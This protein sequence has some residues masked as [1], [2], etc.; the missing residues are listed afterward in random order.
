MGFGVNPFNYKMKKQMIIAHRGESFI[1]PENTLASV[2]LAWENGADAVEVDIRLTLDKKIVVIHDANTKRVSGIRK[3]VSKTELS[4]LKLL[5]AGSY[6]GNQYRGEKIPTLPE[7]L[8][9]VPENGKILI[10]I[11][12]KKDIIP[13]LKVVLEESK[14]KTEQV[15]IISFKLDV[16]AETKKVMPR[17]KAHW[18]VFKSKNLFLRIFSPSWQRI[19]YKLKK[20]NLDGLD[21]WAGYPLKKEMVNKLKYAG[22]D[23]YVWT[24]NDA[25]RAR[26]LLDIG[27][28]GITT[29][30]AGW[31]KEQLKIDSDS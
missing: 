7:I 1:A 4:V 26:E 28:N 29:D 18:I 20:Y 2:L 13:Y 22:L 9:T 21:L 11:K 16:L 8:E 12:S 23:V 24:V 19:M 27:V 5:D 25:G 17:F 15:E 10:E 6:K 30:R 14:L 3:K 31:L